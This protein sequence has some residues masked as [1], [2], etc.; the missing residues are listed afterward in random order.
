MIIK[1]F[2]GKSPK[3]SGAYLAETATVIGDVVVEKDA[4][5]WYGAVLRGDEGPIT[6]G[7]RTSIQDNTILHNSSGVPC[8]IGSDCVV[9]HNV[10]LHSCTI[11]NGC[12]IGIGSVILDNT[13]IGEKCIIAAGSVV[14]P[15]SV[16]PPY[17]MVMGVPG[18]VVRSLTD[19]DLEHAVWSVQ[20]YI[21]L[22][23][24]ELEKQSYPRSGEKPFLHWD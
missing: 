12:L 6:V 1:D 11:G 5:V 8:I 21:D 23:E 19:K 14:P 4:S 10:N 24:E 7:A 3:V 15:R 13:V 2:K 9:G 18:K 20:E 17:S 22:S 16:I